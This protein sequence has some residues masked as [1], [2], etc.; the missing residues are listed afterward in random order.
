M[1]H[2][3]AVRDEHAHRGQPVRTEPRGGG[4]CYINDGSDQGIIAHNLF[5]KCENAAVRTRTLPDRFVGGRGG[6][7]RWNEFFANIFIDSGRAIHLS[8]ADNRADGNLYVRGRSPGPR[9]PP[10]N[11]NWV[12]APED[13]K[14]NVPAWQRVYGFDKQGPYVEL[15]AEIDPAT[16]TL[17]WSAAGKVPRL[18]TGRLY[19][20]DLRGQAAGATRAAGPFVDVP[21]KETKISIDPRRLPA[22]SERSAGTAT[23]TSSP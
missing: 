13:L 18:R 1:R 16:L 23:L 3:R 17:T 21:G 9:L 14:L 15:K 22:A 12:D 4:W 10:T 5:G 20:R 19:T 6:T 8:N 7:A 2:R 11:L